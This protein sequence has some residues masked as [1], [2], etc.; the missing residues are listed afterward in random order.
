MERQFSEQEVTQVIKRAAE[1]QERLAPA[2]RHLGGIG[3]VEIVR[4]AKELGVEE[5]FVKQALADRSTFASEDRGRM[6]AM[7]RTIERTAAGL[8][9]SEA[10]EVVLDSIGP[11]NGLNSS[12]T[13]VGD[14]MTYQTM[15]GISHVEMLINKKHGRTRVKADVST[16]LP[17]IAFGAPLAM[18]IAITAG[19]FANFATVAGIPGAIAATIVAVGGTVGGWFGL[20]AINKWSNK[21][22]VEKVEETVDRLNSE[23]DRV[24]QRGGDGG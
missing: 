15:I 22:V 3:E 23:A 6:T 13:T 4:I 16:F 9:G 20:R 7:D 10:F 5:R 1:L 21:K 2:Q 12:P 14:T 17:V 19:S 11:S 24:S 8:P 18:A